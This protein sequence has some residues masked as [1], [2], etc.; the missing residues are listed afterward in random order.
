MNRLFLY[1]T[2]RAVREAKKDY[3]DREGFLPQMMR[4][5]EFEKRAVLVEGLSLVD[6]AER[7][8]ILRE[9]VESIEAETLH[10]DKALMRFLTDSEAFFRFFEE[11]G[12]ESVSM[13][14]LAQADAYAEFVEHISLLERLRERYRFLLHERGLIDKEEIPERY[15]LNIAY[16][17]SFDEIVLEAEGFFTRFEMTLYTEIAEYVPFFVRMR[18]HRFMKKMTERFAYEGIALPYEAE[19]V[20][21]LGEKRVVSA[22][23]KPVRIEA[24][25]IAVEERLEQAAAIMVEVDAMVREGIAPESIAVVLPDERFAE[26]LRRFDRAGNFNFAMGIEL[27]R[28]AY[29]RALERML[30]VLKNPLGKADAPPE[31]F[32]VIEGWRETLLIGK[33]DIARFFTAVETV[34][35]VPPKQAV[36]K[37]AA[38]KER[39]ERVFEGYVLDSTEWLAIWRQALSEVTLDDIGGGKVTVMG[40]LETRAVAFEGVVVADFNEAYVPA[41]SSKERFLNTQVR[42]FAGLPTKEDREALQK[43]YYVRLLEKARKAT[44]VYATSDAR[45]PS[46]FLYELGLSEGKRR[47]YGFDILYPSLPVTRSMEGDPKVAFEASATV[48]SASRLKTFLECRRKYFYKY[49]A[50]VKPLPLEEPLEGSVIHAVLQRVHSEPIESETQFYKRLNEAFA[51]VLPP[52]TPHYRYKT[53]LW[54]EL[55]RGYARTQTAHFAEGWQVAAREEAFACEI[56]GLRFE[57]RIDRIDTK[58][59]RRLLIDYKTG[60]VQKPTK[61]F[62]PEKVTD[63]QMAIYALA[64]GIEEESAPV[65]C[66]VFE[67]GEF[68]PVGHLDEHIEALRV[69]LEEIKSMR[70]LEA[71]RCEE[72]QRC[73]YCDYALLCG[74]AEYAYG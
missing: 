27:T 19:T 5:D 25:T 9:A 37:I 12:V 1:P 64:K 63:Y 65:Y 2:S 15:A 40:V 41:R 46:R 33:T 68:V 3:G 10:I 51:L 52:E 53:A 58:E 4:I 49:V 8:L 70:Y 35:P 73:R 11:L 34:L 71:T 48:W 23:E 28:F 7:V 42:R 45:L 21:S 69:R 39:Y 72:E 57:G 55:L 17:A 26:I 16:I 18:T 29:F 13:E 62:D 20:V 36:E 67:G 56:A 22:K 50:K 14:R 24:K 74:R 38:L 44:I 47:R 6:R 43:H 31:A 66:K 30:D 61:T 59:E 60:N 54:R 32:G